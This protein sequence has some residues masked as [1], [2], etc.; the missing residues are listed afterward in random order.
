MLD[1]VTVLSMGITGGCAEA[2]CVAADDAVST[3]PDVQ[4]S[5]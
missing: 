5:A 1:I 3:V 2:D 4:E